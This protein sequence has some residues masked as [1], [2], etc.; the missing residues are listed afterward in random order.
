MSYF[1]RSNDLSFEFFLRAWRIDALFDFFDGYFSASPFSFEYLGRIS[2]ADFFFEYEA[3]KLDDIL[4]C[5]PF[6]LFN[7]EF[8]QINQIVL[9]AGLFFTFLLLKF[10]WYYFYW[11]VTLYFTLLE[12]LLLFLFKHDNQIFF[13]GFVLM[14][15]YFSL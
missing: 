7:Y 12:F 6:D 8:S 13:L 1:D 10:I 2:I 9:F 14:S 4:F 5:I 3:T 15:Y 11:F